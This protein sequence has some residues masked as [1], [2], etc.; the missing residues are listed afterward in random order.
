MKTTPSALVPQQN[1]LA[2][3]ARDLRFCPALTGEPQAL[4]PAQIAG[5]NRDGYVSGL[6]LFDENEAAEHRRFFDDLLLAT[7][8]AGGD[9]YS[10]T[11]AH[12][13]YP[14]V[15]DLLRHPRL[16]APVRDLLGNDV[17][18][19]GAH[20]FC[21]LPGDNKAVAWHQDAVYWPLTPAKTVTAWLAID[22]ADQDNAC[23]RFLPGS[24]TSGALPH[25]PSAES[26]NNVL[27]HTAASVERYGDPV[28]NE[29]RAGQF[30]LHSDLL[31]HG[32]DVNRSQRRR[33]GLTLRFCAA[34]VRAYL[35]WDAKGVVVSGTDAN[36]HWANAPRPPA[37]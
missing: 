8:A 28:D 4:T 31:L 32:S 12:L 5:Y 25:L 30:S 24:H 15:Y 33:C 11:T 2:Q 17:I 7:V 13:K 26:E 34:D 3:I 35:G 29:L 36:Q 27:D 16:I 18:G 14:E 10:I 9:G 22:D 23:M 21:K 37:R 19:W 6:R 1:E 20:Y